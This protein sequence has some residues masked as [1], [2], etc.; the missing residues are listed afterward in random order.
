MLRS[1]YLQVHDLVSKE[2]NT[3]EPYLAMVNEYV[4]LQQTYEQPVKAAGALAKGV[5]PKKRQAKAKAG[6][7]QKRQ[8]Q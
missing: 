6:S 5:A 3:S 1:L 7:E 2:V 8:K 4:Q